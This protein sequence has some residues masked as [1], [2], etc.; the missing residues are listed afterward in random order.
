M[1]YAKKM[2]VLSVCLLLPA[3]LFS[4]GAGTPTGFIP[5]PEI[6]SVWVETATVNG[7]SKQTA[8][9][10]LDAS[11]N[12]VTVQAASSQEDLNALAAQF[13]L[14]DVTVKQVSDTLQLSNDIQMVTITGTLSGQVVTIAI[15]GKLLDGKLTNSAGQVTATYRFTTTIPAASY[16][17]TTTVVKTGTLGADGKISYSST[18]ITQDA[19]Q[20]TTQASTAVW[21]LQS[22]SPLK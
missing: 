13:K 18:T 12:F 17:S 8:I 15:N 1:A 4:C 5:L 19:N 9:F 14:T 21:T 7:Q 22:G 10:S 3:V 20:P 11:N 2:M 6:A 16:T